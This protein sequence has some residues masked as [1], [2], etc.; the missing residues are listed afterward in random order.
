M[1]ALK[2]PQSLSDPD[3]LQ[4]IHEHDESLQS[5]ITDLFD[6]ENQVGG[7]ICLISPEIAT[8]MII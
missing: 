1:V 2:E 5:K 3:D 6:G 4:N 7:K 8:M